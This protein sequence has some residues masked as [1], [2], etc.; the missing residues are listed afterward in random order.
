MSHFIPMVSSSPPPFDD[1]SCDEYDDDF[2]HFT[3]ADSSIDVTTDN[4]DLIPD[5]DQS[6]ADFS[7]DS[8]NLSN[9]IQSKHLD[10]LN[11]KSVTTEQ[12]T[13]KPVLHKLEFNTTHICPDGITVSST[14]AP[15]DS[16]NNVDLVINVVNETTAEFTEKRFSQADSGLCS[17]DASPG[18]RSDEMSESYDKSN[19]YSSDGEETFPD[20]NTEESGSW[21]NSAEESQHGNN[22]APE[23]VQE[24]PR[25]SNNYNAPSCNTPQTSLIEE[26]VRPPA[27]VSAKN[28][29]GDVQVA[30]PSMPV[31]NEET[32]GEIANSLNFVC[33]EDKVEE[34]LEPPADG[35]SQ[36]NGTCISS[37]CGEDETDDWADF[38]SA[39]VEN[40]VQKSTLQCTD[41]SSQIEIVTN[42]DLQQTEDKL[43]GNERN[44][45]SASPET[46]VSL[47]VSESLCSEAEV[48]LSALESV[49]PET[50]CSEMR[51]EIANSSQPINAMQADTLSEEDTMHIKPGITISEREVS[52]DTSS[53]ELSGSKDDRFCSESYS[54]DS[55]QAQNSHS[56]E[57]LS[58]PNNTDGSSLDGIPESCTCEINISRSQNHSPVN[59]L[60]ENTQ[61]SLVTLPHKDVSEK[62]QILENDGNESSKQISHDSDDDFDDFADFSSAILPPSQSDDSERIGNSTELSN[63]QSQSEISSGR[64]GGNTGVDIEITVDAGLNP[65]GVKSSGE[66]VFKERE[67]SG[68]SDSCGS[69]CEERDEFGRVRL[70][71]GDLQLDLPIATCDTVTDDEADEWVAFKQNTENTKETTSSEV[72]TSSSSQL[73][74]PADDDD[75]AEFGEESY[76]V[77]SVS[78]T[79]TAASSK[80]SGISA[81]RSSQSSAVCNKLETVVLGCF[82]RLDENTQ[83]LERYIAT[84]R[85]E[86]ILPKATLE[87]IPPSDRKQLELWG[88]LKDLDNTRALGYQWAESRSNNNMY[89][90]LGIDVRNI[91]INGHKKQQIPVYATHLTLLEPTKGPVASKKECPLVDTVNMVPSVE[92]SNKNV[93]EVR[94]DW[95]GSGLTNPLEASNK[96][97][98]LDFLVM[99]EAEKSKKTKALEY[100][101]L[102][103]TPP[104][105]SSIQPLESILANLKP[106]A[107]TRSKENE[108]LSEEVARIVGTLPD[109]S[110]MRAKVLMFPI[111]HSEF[112]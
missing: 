80:S 59:I 89:R 39:M 91:V 87:Y 35:G 44:S 3:G 52:P 28:T 27:L 90:T 110:F 94:F 108:K 106:T 22:T 103:S 101:L 38:S 67:V 18:P 83:M 62:S 15:N 86:P 66:E 11:N 43:G 5:R 75:W 78:S 88:R 2:G 23:T 112:N 16:L 53:D 50:L 60:T 68:D 61:S 49:C 8:V 31:C 14:E 47:S 7:D 97:L 42:G 109:L 70:Y 95:G 85:P 69:N 29:I 54:P 99:Q 9:C 19:T 98:N 4:P 41:E 82:E 64:F 56:K 84:T 33:N 72:V 13:A 48:P 37:E 36:Y 26:V 96:S 111:R 10:G 63:A 65:S 1:A 55:P 92:G 104:G 32:I 46:E 24:I 6:P 105:K 107:V 74:E 20:F 81:G 58:S 34:A 76:T 77:P 73:A 71:S 40:S 25:D 17:S 30:K 57:D 102:E 100:E 51:P 21:V 45:E 93:P 12:S 79:V